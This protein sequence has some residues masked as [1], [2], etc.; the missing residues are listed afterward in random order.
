MGC[1]VTDWP[2]I[3]IF[4][5][6]IH[7]YANEVLLNFFCS[8][9]RSIGRPA[10]RLKLFLWKSGKFAAVE[11]HNRTKMWSSL[12]TLLLLCTALADATEATPASSAD[13]TAAPEFVCPL[14]CICKNAESVDCRGAGIRN[15]S[16]LLRHRSVIKLWVFDSFLFE[17]CPCDGH[18]K[19]RT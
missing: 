15:I 10:S 12:L 9:G 6:W 7:E 8:D 14:D 17:N 16:R 2:F 3:W 18:S 1:D 11:Q 5:W 13:V 19:L 4:H